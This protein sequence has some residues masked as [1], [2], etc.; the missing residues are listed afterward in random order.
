MPGFPAI[1]VHFHPWLAGLPAPQTTLAALAVFSPRESAVISHDFGA[2]ST[3]AGAENL[4]YKI[5]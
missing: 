1:L 4:V 2:L 5:N 3:V